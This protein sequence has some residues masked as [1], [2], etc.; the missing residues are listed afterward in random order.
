MISTP[1]ISNDPTRPAAQNNPALLSGQQ[2]RRSSESM[3]PVTTAAAIEPAVTQFSDSQTE[4]SDVAESSAPD[5][6]HDI[7][8]AN[9]ADTFMASLRAGILTQP[10]TA[11][12]AQA[13]FSPQSVLKLLE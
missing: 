9:T 1:N 3:T 4:L 7:G 12:L 8:D 5:Y 6:S 13:N 10:G 11:M 2:T